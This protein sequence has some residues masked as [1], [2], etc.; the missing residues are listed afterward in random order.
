MNKDAKIDYPDTLMGALSEITSAMS[1]I[2]M[3]PRPIKDTPKGAY[4]MESDEWA[5]HS[6]EHMEACFQL[7]SKLVME[8]NDE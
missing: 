6:F 1:S 5:R 8:R 2:C 4:L 7:I 3:E